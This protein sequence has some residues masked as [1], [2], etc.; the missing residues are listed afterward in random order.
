MASMKDYLEKTI[1]RVGSRGAMPSDAIIQ[2]G[3][4]EWVAPCDGYVVAGSISGSDGDALA[5]RG[6]IFQSISRAPAPNASQEVYVQC[7][8]GEKVSVF[9]SAASQIT[10]RFF[11]K[12]V[13][14]GLNSLIYKLFPEVRHA[15]A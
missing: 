4:N 14:G 15:Y 3:V 9:F 13:G 7:R 2:Y 5:A 12:S 10:K 11:V 8:K 1:L 6:P